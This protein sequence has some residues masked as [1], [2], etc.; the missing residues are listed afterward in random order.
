MKRKSFSALL[1]AS[2]IMLVLP[3]ACCKRMGIET[4]TIKEE[5]TIKLSDDRSESMNIGFDLEIPTG[6]IKDNALE[7]VRKCLIGNLFGDGCDCTV[8][9]DADIKDMIDQHIARLAAEYRRESAELLETLEDTD[10]ELGCLNRE[11]FYTARFGEPFRGL[12]S[13]VVET[14]SYTGGAHGSTVRTGLCFSLSD[15]M[16][17][18]ENDLF[19]PGYKETLDKLLRARLESKAKSEGFADSIFNRDIE[20]NGNF[21]ISPEGVN[22]IYGQ[23]EIGPYS[24]GIIELD[25][26]WDELESRLSRWSPYLKEDRPFRVGLL[27][28]L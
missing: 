2:A 28:S 11:F 15:G 10:S 4:E 26:S 12:Q 23:Y 13:C 22:Y 6:G 19:K 7:N 14:Y 24:L 25:L 18:L 16:R 8:D 17:V 5:R 3:L 27:F 20:A 1:S 21:Y 9:S